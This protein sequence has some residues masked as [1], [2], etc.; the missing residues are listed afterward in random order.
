[1]KI[2]EIGTDPHEATDFR[3]RKAD[4]GDLNKGVVSA[5]AG[6]D[7]VT[8]GIGTA[9]FDKHNVPPADRA[10]GRAAATPRTSPF[11]MN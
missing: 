7:L 3:N 8:R 9:Y 11:A 4:T 1:M 5:R 2:D 6:L 10:R